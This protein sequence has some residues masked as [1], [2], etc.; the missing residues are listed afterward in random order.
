MKAMRMRIMMRQTCEYNKRDM[1]K[2]RFWYKVGVKIVV[3]KMR[4]VRLRWLRHVNRRC[5]N[6]PMRRHEIGYG[7]FDER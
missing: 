4:K 6:T 3:D 7:G 2:K 5:V 1:I